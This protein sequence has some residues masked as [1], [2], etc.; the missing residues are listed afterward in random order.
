VGAAEAE[1]AVRQGVLDEHVLLR[2]VRPISVIEINSLKSEICGES[3]VIGCDLP[4]VREDQ[5]LR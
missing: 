5:P 1:Q 3:C 2:L 4:M